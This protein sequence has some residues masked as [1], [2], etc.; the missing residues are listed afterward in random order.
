MKKSIEPRFAEELGRELEAIRSG[1]AA[2]LPGID[3]SPMP[4][5][6]RVA[7]LAKLYRLFWERTI[8]EFGLTH[9]EQQVLG[10]LRSKSAETP[11][12]LA[13]ITHLTPA[14]M[15]R[16]LDRLEVQ[17]L[18]ERGSHPTDRRKIRVI[19]TEAGAGVAEA[20]LQA[21]VETQHSL[22]EGLDEPSL[23]RISRAL[24]ELL[25]RLA[26]GPSSAADKVA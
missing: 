6:G 4:L 5:F 18:V 26:P 7:A 1:I 17:G 15:T 9:A 22:L 19:L 10:I 25:T 23:T 21:E 20:M 14:G 16:T 13:R 11:G 8:G 3:W 2:E 24:D 12:E